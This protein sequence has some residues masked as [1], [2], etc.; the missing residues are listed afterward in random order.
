MERKFIISCGS[1]VDMPYAYAQQRDWKVIFYTYLIDGTE[2]VDD[3]LRD[4]AALP[5]F[6]EMLDEK[7]PQTSQINVFKYEEFFEPL[8]QQADV[9]HIAFGSGMSGSVRNAMLA[10]QELNEKYEHQITVIDSLCSSSGYGL[11]VDGASDL[12]DEGKTI[13]ETAA[14]VMENRQRIHHQFFSSN[15]KHFRRSGRVSGPA[16]ALGTI[17]NICPLMRLDDGGR[18]IAYDKIRG[19]Q[20]AIEHTVKRMLEHA[21]NGAAYSGKCCICHSQCLPDAERL[22]EAVKAAFANVGQI[23]I[24]DIGTIIAAHSGPGTVAIFFFGDPREPY[25]E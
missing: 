23:E 20:K 13:E 19:K 1:T 14:W 18:I 16:A 7:M 6:Y 12:R 3:M 22:R 4:P 17:L 9:L 25:T 5:H 8:V 11:L 10:A 21:E 15:L 2:Y 24:Y